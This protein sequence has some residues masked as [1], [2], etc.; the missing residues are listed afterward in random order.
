VLC[1]AALAPHLDNLDLGT[2]GRC[3]QIVNREGYALGY[4]ERYEQPLWVAYRL[5]AAEVTNAPVRRASSFHADDAIATGSATPQDYAGSGFDRGHLA[6]AADMRFSAQTMYDS[7][8]MA[9]VSP[10]VPQFNRGVWRVL[11]DKVRELALRYDSVVVVT[12]PVFATNAPPAI[13][14]ANGVGVPNG[15]YKIIC[16]TNVPPWICAYL[17]PNTATN[18]P[19]DMFIVPTVEV[20]RLTGLDFFSAL[21][22]EVQTN[23]KSR[24]CSPLTHVRGS[25]NGIYVIILMSSRDAARRYSWRTGESPPAN[26]YQFVLQ[27]NRRLECRKFHGDGTGQKAQT[28]FLLL[29]FTKA[30]PTAPTGIQE[31][32]FL[33]L[34]VDGEHNTKGRWI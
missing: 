7:F 3:D 17:L 30:I 33:Y 8:S 1:A 27:S 2:P 28:R 32:D 18:A 29:Y 34:I 14:G 23:L 21:P 31:E 20:E 24:V 15:F 9:N 19:P 4:S 13:I 10:Q 22:A 26:A 12:G 6:P 5:T 11:E 16:C 25:A